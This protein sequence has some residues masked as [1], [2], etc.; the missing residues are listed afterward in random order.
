MKFIT[1]VREMTLYNSIHTYIKNDVS[2]L[3][4]IELFLYD[5]NLQPLLLCSPCV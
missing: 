1:S 2:S 4:N 5:M 3:T